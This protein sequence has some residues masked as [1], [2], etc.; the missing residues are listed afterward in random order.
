MSTAELTTAAPNLRLSDLL[1]VLRRR[2]LSVVGAVFVITAVVLMF[3]LTEPNKYRATARILL[4]TVAADTAGVVD[5]NAQVPFFADRQLKNAA[6]LLMSTGT[7]AAVSAQYRGRADVHAVTAV[8]M[9]D[10]SDVI[11]VSVTATK[12]RDAANLVNLYAKTFI[13]R[14]SKERADALATGEEN[15]QKQIADLD[16]ERARINAPLEDINTQLLSRPGDQALLRQRQDLTTQLSQQLQPIEAQR[17]VYIQRLQNVRLLSG[18]VS[19]GVT[20]QLV[21]EATP[22]TSPVSPTPVRDAVIGVMFGLGIGIALAFGREFLD[23]SIRGVDDLDRLTGGAVPTLGVVPTF[24]GTDQKLITVTSPTSGSAEAFRALRTSVRF[25]ALDRAMKIIQVTSPRAG[26]GKTTIVANLG[27]VLAQAGH[28][29]CVVSCDLRGPTIHHRFGEQLSPGLTD[30]LLGECPL[31]EAL[32]QTQSGVYLLPSGPRPPNPSELLGSMRTQ[33]AL[34]VLSDRFDFVLLDSTPVLPVTDA[35][36]ISQ[37]AQA[38]LLVVAAGATSRHQ[39][40]ESMNVL[41]R[42]GA[43]VVG[44]VLNKA[45]RELDGYYYYYPH[46]P[47]PEEQAG[48]R[49]GRSPAP[50]LEGQRAK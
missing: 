15:L 1:Q 31:S 2:W 50:R 36:V 17:N 13:E 4:R 28:S 7:R 37:F 47:T 40:R 46:E 33:T 45:S 48:R 18:S 41:S 44:T 3:S 16:A 8:P 27:V 21:T 11:E 38:T 42:A 22:P 23:E 39:V 35:T 5:P 26:D 34:N 24:E 19:G 14:S 43:S 30:V 32:R 9:T 12:P 6:Q 25:I 49:G 29:V 10:G 20:A